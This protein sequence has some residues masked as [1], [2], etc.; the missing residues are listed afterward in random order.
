MKYATRL[1]Q[2]AAVLA[3]AAAAC[4]DANHDTTAP[5]PDGVAA[6]R[7]SLS[8]FTSFAIART[9]GGYA[10]AITDCMANGDVGAM[11]VHYANTALLDGT[12]D[13]LQPEALIYEPA[14]NGDA[15]L[16]GVE[17][18]VPFAAVPKTAAAPEL[19]GQKF[20]PNDVFGVWGLHVWTHRA[21]PSGI[22]SPWN[23][24]VHC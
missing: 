9:S 1:I 20:Q 8:P 12:V 22:F 2:C 21:N 14:T 11:G 18:I 19:F 15:V 6:L 10:T 5:E 13:P 7:E 17:F 24:R 3:V 4:S 23:P 16:V